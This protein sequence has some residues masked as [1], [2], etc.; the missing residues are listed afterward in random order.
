MFCDLTGEQLALR[1]ELR[2][3]FSGLLSPGQRAALLTERHGTVYRDVVRRMGRDGWLGVGWP[4]STAGAGS[5]RWNSRSSSAR[6]PGRTC[7]CPR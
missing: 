7:R 1:E 4:A 5:A 6:R 2:G 3:Y